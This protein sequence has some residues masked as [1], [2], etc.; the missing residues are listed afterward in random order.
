MCCLS[1]G[2]SNQSA[3]PAEVMIHFPDLRHAGVPGAFVFPR[4]LICQDCG[5]SSFTTPASEITLLTSCDPGRDVGRS[6]T[7]IRLRA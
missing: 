4:L 7:L 5:F 3:F 1:C 2:S 6:E